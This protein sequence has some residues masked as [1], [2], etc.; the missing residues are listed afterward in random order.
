MFLSNLKKF[1]FSFSRVN[2]LD[3]KTFKDM[4]RKLFSYTKIEFLDLSYNNLKQY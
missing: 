4:I 1:G 2:E 3:E